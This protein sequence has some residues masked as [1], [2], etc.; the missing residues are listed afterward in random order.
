MLI[1]QTCH[2]HN[3]SVHQLDVSW[4][5]GGAASVREAHYCPS[6]AKA[7]GIPVNSAP[8]FSKVLGMLS[9]AFLDPSEKAAA[10]EA[11]AAGEDEAE[12]PSCPECGWTLRD[13]RQ[14]NRLGCPHDYE[15][16]ADQVDEILERMHGVNRH[17]DLAEESVLDRLEL[18]LD[19]AVAKEDYEAAARLR[20]DIR[21]LEE[22]LDQEDGM[23]PSSRQDQ[24]A[25]KG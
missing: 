6:C 4:A 7:A 22:A 20:D 5:D 12:S 25:D 23:D 10:E 18:E 1:C 13:L 19:E 15:V 16:F 2:K 14:S 9:K 17:A 21:C 24:Q 11:A 3:A 8:P